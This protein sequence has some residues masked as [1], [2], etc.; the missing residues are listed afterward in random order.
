MITT[1]L[2]AMAAAAV[3]VAGDAAR[4]DPSAPQP[5]E[6]Q[7]KVPGMGGELHVDGPSK[8]R[9]GPMM[10]P[11]AAYKGTIIFRTDLNASYAIL[12]IGVPVMCMTIRNSEL[13]DLPGSNMN[14]IA[15]ESPVYKGV[16]QYHNQTSD[17]WAGKSTSGV[18]MSLF[19]LQGTQTIV[20]TRTS[21]QDM[22]YHSFEAKQQ[23]DSLFLPPSYLTCV[24][25]P[26]DTSSLAAAHAQAL[27]NSGRATGFAQVPT[28]DDMASSIALLRSVAEKMAPV[29]PATSS[30]AQK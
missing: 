26:N 2:S 3:V 25:M 5:N 21:A 23:E 8:L 24:P 30:I 28:L 6:W 27:E 16:Q 18:D 7:A 10:V 9:L 13:P 29:R 19:A 1:L 17:V 15:L 11:D 12:Y 22:P 4:A 20:G 14:L